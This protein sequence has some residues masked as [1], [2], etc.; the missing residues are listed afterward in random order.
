MTWSKDTPEFRD[1]PWLLAK[2]KKH[3]NQKLLCISKYDAFN[4]Y[5]KI[6]FSAVNVHFDIS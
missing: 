3:F 5:A 4:Y 1:A 6:V 2:A